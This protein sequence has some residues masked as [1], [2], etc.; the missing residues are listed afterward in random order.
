M[1]KK[2][3]RSLRAR[4]RYWFD[5]RMALGTR[6]MIDLLVITIVAVM[7]VLGIINFLFKWRHS[8]PESIWS[9]FLHTLDPGVLSESEGSLGPIVVLTAATVFGLV[10]TGTLIAII[11]NWLEERMLQLRKGYSDV[12][13]DNHVVI[14]GYDSETFTII[15]QLIEA[16]KNAKNRSIVVLDADVSK[17]QMEDEIN[18]HF[19]KKYGTN[20]ICRQGN[21]FSHVA[22]NMCSVDTAKSIVINLSDDFETIKSILTISQYLDSMQ[23][24][25]THIVGVIK[26]RKNL[27]AATIAGEG[28][29]HN[30]NRT[31]IVFFEDCI[32][33][34]IAQSSR[35]TGLS[36]IFTELFNYENN[37]IYV[38]SHPEVYGKS[39]ID[40]NTSCK[41][42]IV[43]G[44]VDRSGYLP[45]IVLNPDQNTIIQKNQDVILLAEDDNTAQLINKPQPINENAFSHD[46]FDY[47]EK[48]KKVLVLGFSKKL[49][50]VITEASCFL[51]D[52][53]QICVVIPQGFAFHRYHAGYNYEQ[54]KSMYLDE[55]PNQKWLEPMVEYADIYDAYFIKKKIKTYHPDSVIVLSDPLL[56]YEEAD[57]R[58]LLLLLILKDII[59]KTGSHFFNIT[60]EMRLS[61]NQK[62]AQVTGVDNFVV[63]TNITSLILSQVSQIKEL[64]N[65]FSEII[66]DRGAEIYVRDA[67]YYLDIQQPVNFFTA[68]MAVARKKSILLGYQTKDNHLCVTNPNKVA[69]ID[70][71]E[72]QKLIVLADD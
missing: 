18:Y 19:L 27:S 40:L 15:G 70:F 56:T 48:P 32:A 1:N 22:L 67:S 51:A 38:E 37:E 53:S 31:V 25:S 57:A 66:E 50:R 45:E 44:Y 28:Y 8:I 33:K 61:E 6:A 10:V 16:N 11:N 42:A 43:M 26:D 64:W 4:L 41:N 30:K 62:I 12:L 49:F 46:Q 36:D 72:V 52:G 54:L 47:I 2:N 17:E 59:D 14:I 71:S 65:I 60:S 5:N 21:I 35:Q 58:T 55:N 34:I 23:N 29:T 3:K 63:G 39:I 13:E 20:I 9:I 69:I 24:T 7:S 68:Q